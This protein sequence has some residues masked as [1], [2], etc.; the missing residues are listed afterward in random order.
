[1]N[2][3]SLMQ[4]LRA[5]Y[6]QSMNYGHAVYGPEAAG[7]APRATALRPEAH[8]QGRQIRLF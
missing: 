7:T 3:F 4:M 6:F 8:F 2:F 5:C 1:M